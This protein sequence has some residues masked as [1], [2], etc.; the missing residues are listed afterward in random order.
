M[1]N[2]KTF[3][4]Y[5]LIAVSLLVIGLFTYHNITD[6]KKHEHYKPLE[7][8]NSCLA[9]NYH[10]I[11]SG[12]LY[13][14]TL[15]LMSNSNELNRYNVFKDDFEAQLKWMTAHGATFVSEQQLEESYKTQRFPAGCVWLS[16]DD[17]DETT[18]TNAL[19]ILKKY[20]VP[21]TVF[22]IAGQ[23]GNKD[24][25][26]I[27]L[28]TWTE[29][30]KMKD[31]GLITF[32]SHTYNMHEL[33]DNK[34]IFN[35]VP[36]AEFK[37]DLLKSKATLKKELGID[38]K[39]FAYPYGNANDKTMNVVEQAGFDYAYILA[40]HAI[41]T[42]NYRSLLNRIMVDDETFERQVK[43]WKGFKT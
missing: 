26:N 16:F 9:L 23:V 29:L 15:K 27:K 28:A 1:P 41:T 14:R 13:E 38:A 40:P 2:I 5:A 7:A 20:H 8:H 11:R 33:L 25:N 31:S 18:Y 39:S 17:G 10:R 12:T 24:F 6:E 37:A 42:D 36:A 22:V 30:R 21:A 3:L 35:K 34:P 19:P 43:E 32:G 4:T